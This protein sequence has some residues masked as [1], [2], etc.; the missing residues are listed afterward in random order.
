MSLL[1]ARALLVMAHLVAVDPVGGLHSAADD[2]FYRMLG[3]ETDATDGD[4]FAGY[5]SQA[6]AWHPKKNPPC[7]SWWRIGKVICSTA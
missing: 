2:Y 7:P 6:T 5:I 4:V 1:R 3:L